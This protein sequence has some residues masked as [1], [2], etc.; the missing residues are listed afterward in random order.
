MF[1]F[2]VYK[3]KKTKYTIFLYLC[4]SFSFSVC[5]FALFLSSSFPVFV[6]RSLPGPPPGASG[7]RARL[8]CG[9][10]PARRGRSRGARANGARSAWVASHGASVCGP[11]ARG[12]LFLLL[13]CFLFLFFGFRLNKVY[14]TFIRKQKNYVFV[15]FAVFAACVF[16]IACLNKVYLAFIRK[17]KAIYVVFFFLFAVVL[18]VLL[19]LLFSLFK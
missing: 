16:L 3:L 17:N 1:V 8:L 11:P 5:L 4:I 7:L 18:S 6:A 10:T 15:L 13:F 14:G 2:V 9:R 12:L 19:L